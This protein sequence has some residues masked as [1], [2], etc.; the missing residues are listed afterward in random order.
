MSGPVFG[1]GLHGHALCYSDALGG[2]ECVGL[3]DCV[4]VAKVWRCE[5]RFFVDGI[6]ACDGCWARGDD[7]R[8][9]FEYSDRLDVWPAGVFFCA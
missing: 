1:E 5:E 3:E 4:R 7:C 9:G 6:E 2:A 8:V